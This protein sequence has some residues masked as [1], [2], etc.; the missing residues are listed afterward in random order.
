MDTTRLVDVVDDNVGDFDDDATASATLGDG[1][2][3]AVDDATDGRLELLIEA[4][5]TVGVASFSSFFT[6]TLFIL[7]LLSFISTTFF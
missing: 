2:F 1:D 5:A 3:T 7:S 6:L 4:L